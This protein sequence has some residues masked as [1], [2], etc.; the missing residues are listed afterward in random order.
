MMCLARH[1]GH[2]AFSTQSRVEG[3]P[4]A[5]VEMVEC[6]VSLQ[7]REVLRHGLE[8]D[9]RSI[10]ACVTRERNRYKPNVRADVI[11]RRAEGVDELLQHVNV[12]GLV[13]AVPKCFCLRSAARVEL[14]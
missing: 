8:G 2:P 5:L 7:S 3:A 9:D 6:G 4:V 13:L 10:T 14:H 11:D 12:R 1:R